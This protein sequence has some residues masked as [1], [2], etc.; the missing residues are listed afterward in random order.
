MPGG[1]G[2]DDGRKSERRDHN[3]SRAFWLSGDWPRR[4]GYS[5][6]LAG[7]P[8]AVSCFEGKRGISQ[9]A[10]EQLSFLCPCGKSVELKTLGRCRA[11]YDQRHHSLRFFGG[12]RERVLARDRYRCRGCGGR[13]RLVVHHRDRSNQPEWLVTLCIGCHTRIHRSSG[14]RHWLSGTLLRLWR[15]LHRHDPM[16]FELAFKDAPL[17]VPAVDSAREGAALELLVVRGGSLSEVANEL[18]F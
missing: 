6:C 12:M 13:S 11:C 16:Q 1:R 2:P 4:P 5:L 3:D 8:L 14:W 10:E 9:K 7:P 18:L 17:E 15:E